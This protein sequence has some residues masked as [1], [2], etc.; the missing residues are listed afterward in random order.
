MEAETRTSEGQTIWKKSM[1]VNDYDVVASNLGKLDLEQ[2]WL[3]KVKRWKDM[4]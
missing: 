3:R 1:R 4:I 2:K